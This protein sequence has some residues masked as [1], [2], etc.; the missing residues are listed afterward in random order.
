VEGA[1]AES[2]SGPEQQ[3]GAQCEITHLVGPVTMQVRPATSASMPLSGGR[4]RVRHF[5]QSKRMH[6]LSREASAVLAVSLCC[7]NHA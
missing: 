2:Q 6:Q 3:L 1:C 4:C 7:E 5:C